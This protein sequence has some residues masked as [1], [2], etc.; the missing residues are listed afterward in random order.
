MALIIHP[1]TGPLRG[2]LAVPADKSISHRAVMLA[3]LA[4]GRSRLANWLPAGDTLA[5][6]Q[7]MRA[8]DV[9]VAVLAQAAN[10]WQLE[11]DGRGLRG[12]APAGRP[13]DCRNAG[14]CMRLLAGV[15]AGQPFASTLDGSPQLRRRPMGRLVDPLRQMGADIRAQ[16]GRAPLAIRPAQLRGVRYSLPVASAQVK[17]ALLLAG[18]YAAGET[19]LIE[20]AASRDH[21]ERLLAAM[22]APIQAE[23]DG[24]AAGRIA[25]QP[26]PAGGE[27]RPLALAVPGD[28]SSAAFLLAAALIVPGS[29]VS[30]QGVG[31]NPRRTGLLDILTA[32]GA[33]PAVSS[34]AMASD[35]AW[36]A[37]PLS[38]EP[39]G[40]VS[41]GYAELR[42]ADLAGELVVRTIDELPVWAVVASQAAG[43][44][45]LREAAELRVKEV[46]RIGLLAAEL[47]KM[48]AQIEELPDG[49]RIQGPCRLQGAAVDSHGDHRLAMALTVAGLAAAGRTSLAGAACI[50]DSYPGFVEALASLGANLTWHDEL[51]KPE[52]RMA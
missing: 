24:A 35:E 50:G 13:L 25:L 18:L 29:E 1:Q 6:L 20:P 19:V 4:A 8:L 12:L 17:S 23:S 49:L 30:V 21:S 41:L 45:Q 28:F 51:S 40:D 36:S 26:L 9:P 5:T 7:A 42:A 32:M 14:T 2:R 34:G 10:G 48:G 3:G 27:L 22:G 37:S 43:V 33:R 52:P 39:A 38:S 15:L 47:R 31:L 46:D 11:V 16:A 44:S